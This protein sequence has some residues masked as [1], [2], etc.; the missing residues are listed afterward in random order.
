MALARQNFTLQLGQ[1]VDTKTDP[2][3]IQIG[4][5]A[6]LENATF[7]ST[8]R[9]TKRPGSAQL[10]ASS[11]PA[12]GNAIASFKDELVVMDGSSVSSYGKQF[13]NL[14][15]KGTKIAVDVTTE[16]I[17]KN[18]YQQTSPDSCLLN[19]LSAYVWQD[20]QGGCHYSVFDNATQQLIINN[21]A[22]AGA[23]SPK[24]L[25]V[26]DSFAIIYVEAGA[27]SY[28]K[29]RVLDALS[30]SSLPVTVTLATISNSN[31]FYDAT[32]NSSFIYLTYTNAAG[33]LA[34]IRFDDS[35]T[36]SSPLTLAVTANQKAMVLGA[37][38]NLRVGYSTGTDVRFVTVD[39]GLT[40]FGT[41]VVIEA[42]ANVVNLTAIETAATT[43]KWYYE[44]DATNAYDH[45]VRACSVSNLT[46]GTPAD[47]NR[48]VGIWSKPFVNGS[49]HYIV[50]VHESELQDTYFVF[51]SA[52]SV[53]AK[54][55]QDNGGNLS[56]N[57]TLREVNAQGGGKFEFAYLI[58]DL[59]ESIGGD[60]YT[61]T[62]VNSAVLSFGN[63]IFTESLGGNLNTSGGIVSAYD[64]QNVVEQNF[65]LY[66]ENVELSSTGIG[67]TLGN[68]SYQYCATY[69]WTDAQGQLHVSAPSVPLTVDFTTTPKFFTGN[70]IAYGGGTTY[71]FPIGGA[72]NPDSTFYGGSGDEISGPGIPSG[73]Y[74]VD[75]LAYGFTSTSASTSPNFF[76]WIYSNF[77]ATNV[78]SQ[79]TITGNKRTSYSASLNSKNISV[80]PCATNQHK[81][82][83][84]SNATFNITT[85]AG[86]FQCY[87]MSVGDTSQFKIGLNLTFTANFGIS[88][89]WVVKKV[90]GNIVYF[91]SPFGPGFLAPL[92][93][94]YLSFTNCASFVRIDHNPASSSTNT[95]T[96]TL[97]A[98]NEL[99]FFVGQRV[100]NNQF[101]TPLLQD[102]ATITNLSYPAP[103]QVTIT[104]NNTV[105]WTGPFAIAFYFT[106][107][108]HWIKPG[109]AWTATTGFSG[110][111]LVESVSQDYVVTLNKV[112]LATGS[113]D[114]S[115]N[116]TNQA[117]IQIPT[118]R[119]TNK[120]VETPV[121][122]AVYRTLV[123]ETLFYRV[124][125][126]S[127]PLLNDKT[128]DFLTFGDTT[129]DSELIGNEQL[130]TTGGVLANGQAPASSLV[131]QYKNR[132]ISVSSEDP[133]TWY[134]SKPVG[135]NTPVQFSP[136][137][138]K[139]IPELGGPITAL[140]V[141][142]DKLIFFK[143][144]SIFIV[145]GT[146]PNNLGLQDDFNDA[147]LVT[148]DTGCLE[149]KSVV[150]MPL[151]LMYKSAKGIYLLDRGLNVKYIGDEVESYNADIVTS[152]ELI[153]QSN[154]VRFTLASGKALVYDYYFDQWSVFT[155]Q[156]A[157]DSTIFEGKFTYLRPD[158]KIYK[159]T[160]GVWTDGGQPI[161][162][163]LKTAWLSFNG[164]QG[165][166]RL[167][168]TMVLGE[169]KSPHTLTV[170]V[171]HDF[172][173]D[174]QTTAIPV[175]TNPGLYQYKVYLTRQKSQSVQ[176][177]V[178][179]TQAGPTY[180][181][182]F[183]ISALGL[184]VGVKK[185]LNTL[186]AGKL[187]G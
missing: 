15:A 105:S 7:Q 42:V 74:I 78:G 146:G 88:D 179:E 38:G 53:V 31:Q 134:F 30:P 173:A 76:P 149:P 81:C 140:G 114:L 67:G 56:Y 177:T 64:G 156:N 130:Y 87:K 19:G 129:P 40:A 165:L 117:A 131:A 73:A 185:G 71:P 123:N 8:N 97:P 133:F 69:E 59:V 58:K 62:G 12:Q 37:F 154:Q 104:F 51:N 57:G 121:S 169:Y 181:E 86:T 115:S 180:G 102:F 33:N 75:G 32:S 124:S 60:V 11:S 94:G 66:P 96:I 45:Y 138:Y 137:F 63:P 48:S 36:P 14:I 122:I 116:Q 125:S 171:A 90:D 27:T 111:V 16:S 35:F 2:K 61:Q 168:N 99:T 144:S 98:D 161:Y 101:Q 10:A 147:E 163:K 141:M 166:E 41:P 25:G 148:T 142:D 22:I 28:I 23:S 155:N 18:S 103:N 113:G 159:E 24:L 110:Q 164:L 175:A 150:R 68:G 13:D 1:G 151:G 3:Q 187:Y 65:F 70:T 135:T 50:L 52:G 107:T 108:P 162:L 128:V 100:I 186:P 80:Y 176:F 4:K 77:T 126:F 21:Q 55:A 158:G 49:D 182:G 39:A 183:N 9:L 29:A 46:P 152:S 17:I 118:L 72:T 132:L 139:K 95:I 127:T 89:Y 119:V 6:E 93:A 43:F 172:E 143:R 20:S 92:P 112:S 82:K 153:E 136:F 47:F 174:S 26:G 85:A 145:V 157:A 120:P 79:I 44:V 54:V 160:P 34:C 5:L 109:Q 170:K 84:D 178:Q 106:Y 91:T 167:Y 184:E 83:I